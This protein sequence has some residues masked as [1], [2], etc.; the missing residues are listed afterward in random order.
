MTNK[1]VNTIWFKNFS[2]LLK[3]PN[4]FFPNEKMSKT[5]RLN[6]LVRAAMYIG[7]ILTVL[8]RDTLYLYIPILMMVVTYLMYEYEPTK[9][10]KKEKFT[11]GQLCTQPTYNNPF[12]NANLITDHR[13]RAP[14]CKYTSKVKTEIKDKFNMNLYRDVGDLYGKN[15]SQREYYTMPST[16]IPNNQTSFAKWCYKSPKTC[17]EESIRC[18]PYGSSPLLA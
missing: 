8:K 17:K 7:V 9:H 11:D 18:V 13:D 4:E 3:Y 12:M 1:L 15:N 14:A 5:R 10:S 6:S 2:V 16:T